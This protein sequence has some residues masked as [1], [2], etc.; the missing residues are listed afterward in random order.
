MRRPVLPAC[1]RVRGRSSRERC[2]ASL[3]LRSAL[4]S[5]RRQRHRP[6]RLQ[7]SRRQGLVSVRRPPRARQVVTLVS[8]AEPS[9]RSAERWSPIRP[10]WASILTARAVDPTARLRRVRQFRLRRVSAPR[11]HRPISADRLRLAALVLHLRKA[12]MA[13]RRA[14]LR[15]A[16]FPRPALVT[17][18]HLHRASVHPGAHRPPT[19]RRGSLRNK[20]SVPQRPATQ[21][22]AARW[23]QRPASAAPSARRE[24]P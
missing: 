18:A 21:R 2:S 4:R 1:R 7:R 20:A 16:A 11:L 10:G 24:I 23:W 12:D 13:R 17:A 19:S 8:R 15:A 22:L 5:R 9:T 14:L 6:R 3:R